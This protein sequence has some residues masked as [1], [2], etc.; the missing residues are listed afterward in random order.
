MKIV[1]LIEAVQ[2]TPDVD[3]KLEYIVV[4]LSTAATANM[5]AMFL[6]LDALDKS[7]GFNKELLK[8]ELQKLRGAPPVSSD[9]NGPMHSQIIGNFLSR[10]T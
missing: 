7:P 1:D 6:L 10:L 9:I 5:N 4:S 8:E 2:G 3:K